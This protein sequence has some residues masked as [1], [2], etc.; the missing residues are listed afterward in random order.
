MVSA[1]C[2]AL[3]ELLEVN[4]ECNIKVSQYIKD[5]GAVKLF[6]NMDFIEIDHATYKKLQAIQDVLF[7]VDNVDS[8]QGGEFYE[9]Y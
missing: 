4:E 6:K 2:K 8:R 7:C 9:D 5:Y 1:L 3:I